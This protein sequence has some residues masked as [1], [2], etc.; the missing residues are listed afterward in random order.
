MKPKKVNKRLFL[1][2]RTVAN[3][4]NTEMIN[5]KGGDLTETCPRQCSVPE[6]ACV[7][8]PVKDCYSLDPECATSNTVFCNTLMNCPTDVVGCD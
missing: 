7:T 6:I 1:N 2:K 8:F 5:V 3:L 4:G